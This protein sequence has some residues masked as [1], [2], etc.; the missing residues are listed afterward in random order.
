MNWYKWE[1]YCTRYY[2]EML[3]PEYAKKKRVRSI[4]RERALRRLRG[5]RH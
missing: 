3:R 4:N 5:M 2:L 1:A